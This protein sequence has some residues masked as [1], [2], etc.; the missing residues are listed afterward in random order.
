MRTWRHCFWLVVVQSSL[1]GRIGRH[2]HNKMQ[3]PLLSSKHCF[4]CRR[5]LPIHQYRWWGNTDSIDIRR[6][7]VML[8]SVYEWVSEWVPVH[9]QD[10]SATQLSLL[11]PLSFS[12]WQRAAFPYT[13]PSI[14]SRCWRHHH[15]HHQQQHH[16]YRPHRAHQC[17]LWNLYCPHKSNLFCWTVNFNFIANKYVHL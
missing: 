8:W 3:F 1:V 10:I 13:A 15:H 6:S 12:C 14:R 9:R 5:V 11:A 4:G 2:K 7:F 16:H 17:S